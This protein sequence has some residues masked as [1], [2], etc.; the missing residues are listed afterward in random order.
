M[1]GLHTS[2]KGVSGYC[3]YFLVYGA[4]VTVCIDVCPEKKRGDSGVR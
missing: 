3:Y 2:R 4:I 1:I